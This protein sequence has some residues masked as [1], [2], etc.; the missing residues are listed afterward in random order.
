MSIL[1]RQT[2]IPA[3][4]AILAALVS[5][6]PAG[7]VCVDAGCCADEA[8]EAACLGCFVNG[9]DEVSAAVALAG[10][11]LVLDL[12]V[13]AVAEDLVPNVHHGRPLPPPEAVPAVTPGLTT[14]IL[15]S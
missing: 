14:T 1:E 13:Q 8:H 9:C 15:R 11:G 6:V 12:P 5:I 3:L 7:S 2:T 10:P 4:L